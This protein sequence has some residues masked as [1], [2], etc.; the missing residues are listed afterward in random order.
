M[1]KLTLLLALLCATMMGWAFEENA[2]FP[3]AGTY[4]NQFYWTSIGGV[5][6]PMG[7][8]SVESKSG[9]DC[10]YVNVGQ[11]DFDPATGIVGC[12][13]AGYEGAGVWI[14]INSLVLADNEIYFKNSG[15]DI[16][17]G[18]VIHNN[19]AGAAPFDPASIDW[20]GVDF[21]TGQTQ[22]KIYFT[23]ENRPSNYTTI[24]IQTAPWA[25]N[26]TGIYVSFPDGVSACSLVDKTGCW[27]EGAQVLMYLTSF[28]DEVTEVTI[29]HA[30]G[31]K[32][33][34]VYNANAGGGSSTPV[35]PNSY[36]AGGHTISLDASYV[37]VD[38]TNKDYTLVITSADDME[39][40]GGSFWNVN[41]VGSDMRT[42]MVVSG[43]KKTITCT[44]T[45]T[46]NPNIYTPLYVLMP[47]E[48]NFGYVT[49]NWED[50]TPLTSEYCNYQGSETQQDGHYFAITWETDPS[51]NV[52]ITIGNGTGAGACSYRNG[53]FEGGNNGLNNF[54]VSDDDFASTTPATDYFTV[55]RPTDG[56][57]EYVLT[58]IADLPAGA[59]IK[60]LSAG[61]IAW[62]EAGADRWCY[63]EF[64][65]TYGAT[66]NQLDAPTNVAIDAN[67]IIT[68][69]AVAGADSY[70]AHVSLGGVEK[71]SQVV[72]S[73]DELTYTALVTGDYI[74]NVVA[75][76]AG[77]VDSDPS[78]DVVWHL[79]AA[80]I[81]LGN[82]E[83]CEANMSSGNTLA[84]FTWE[85]DGSGNIVITISEA[86]G[87]NAADTHFRGNALALANFKVGAGKAA[88]SNYFS[89]PGTTT[90]NQL[91]L[92]A[93]SAPALGEKIYYN[94]VVEYATSL[95]G[96]AWPTLDFEWTYGTECSGIAVS[97]TPN[98]STMGTAVVQ[99]AGVDVTNV[100]DGDEVTFIATVADAELY[101]FVNWTKAGIEVS[102]SATYVTTITET[103]N[104]VAN[105]DYVRN[106]YCHAEITSIQSKKL[107]MT[108]GSIGGG[109]YQI[110]FE[111]SAEAQLTGLNNANY[112][113]NW[114][115]TDIVDGDKK[116]SGQDV[117]FNNAR[118]AFDASGYGSATATFGIADGHTWEDIY[119]WNHAIYFSTAAGEV[120]YTGFPGRHNIDWTATCSDAEAP[121]IAKTEAQILNA[122]DVRLV[123]QATDNW[124]GQLTYTIT[125][126]GAADIILNGASGEE[127]TQDVTGLTT[128]TEYTF[129]VSV[130]DGVN[131]TPTSIVVTP[132]GDETK[133]VMGEASLASKTWNSAIINVAATDNVA[134]TA[135]YIVEL[136]A[137]YVPAEG[138]ITVTGLTAATAYTF[139]IK[140]KDAAGNIS[141][142]SAEV[143]FTTD[144]D[145]TEPTIAAPIPDK[146]AALVKSIYSDTYA[147]APA[148]L[149][150]YNEGW[151]K[152]PV[153][154]EKEISGN[155][156][157][158]YSGDMTGM[159]GWQFGEI[160]VASME[161]VHVDIWP[162][163]N[164]TINMGPTSPDSPNNQVASVALD[165]TGGQ[166]N[167]FDIPLSD[168]TTA[169]GAFNPTQLFQNQF[170][171]YSA[172][173]KFSVDNVYFYRETAIAD[174]ED[175]TA[176]T[177]SLAEESYFSVKINA[178]AED[179]SGAVVYTVK[180]GD[181][182]VA[183]QNAASAVA[184]TINVTGLNAGTAYN[185]NVYVADEA[186]NTL[187]PIELA[188]T[189]K[190]LPAA[191]PTPTHPA[192]AVRSIYSETYAS[193][194]PVGINYN[195]WWWQSPTI[196]QEV[197]LGGNNA[198]YY[199][200]LNTN[201]SFGITWNGDNK[202]D[203]AGYQK[204][205]F[206]IYPTNSATIEIYPVIQPEGEFHRTSATLVGGQWNEV[207]IDYTDKTFAPF[208]QFGIVY[209]NALGDFFID[210]LYFFRDPDYTRTEFLSAGVLGTICLPNNVPAGNAIGATFYA[211]DGK[212]GNG[213]M[214]FEEVSALEAGKPYIFEAQGD[215]IDVYY[216]TTNVEN[217]VN[218]GALQGTFTGVT[219]EVGEADNIYFFR[220]HALWS[221]KET[222]VQI[223]PNRAWLDMSVSIPNHAPKPGKRYITMGVNGQNATT[224]MDQISNDQSQM[225]NK[226][227]IDGHLYILRGEH[228]YNANGQ[229]VK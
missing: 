98:N 130:S 221:A 89:H 8:N 120:G 223:R 45:S 180:N 161:Y 97:A 177:A 175:P 46:S 148:S 147:F 186:G 14:K 95:E 74:I 23:E 210:N 100:N 13:L 117:P 113:I 50:R 81:V 116:M 38:G 139:T 196:A 90:G 15:G 4:A 118:W 109:Q 58:K 208:N 170:T 153:M 158:V 91:V 144:A 30:S 203:A 57:L 227:I 92:T 195:E 75:T 207:I 115:T 145:L 78:A 206:H 34:Y 126:A 200:G 154:T 125:R 29:T 44:A 121:V 24:N 224:G 184:T 216:G 192:V 59:K 156:Y 12:E 124:E 219:F 105:F 168:L 187:E 94:G 87:G 42:N 22:F 10:I 53:G 171:G 188:A 77:K 217:P 93:T 137:E 3:N 198:R 66:C 162:S 43:D 39:G 167:S 69:D 138:K 63:P 182:V 214:V 173:V 201:G 7:V 174:N 55:T 176:F 179:N 26:N 21:I 31:T 220:D 163:V 52:V 209:T 33:L 143:S 11:A 178:Q 108:L 41:G 18:L 112:T 82:S 169:N 128:G 132:V 157:L 229:L 134:V 85:T 194:I 119:V 27:I 111:G 36:T 56:D 80:P 79:E 76:G 215:Q 211:L 20:S 225:T 114:V 106:V 146:D 160:S 51:G 5:T 83:Y 155:H 218:S 190:T 164:G 54:V 9:F 142:D 19:A 183:T 222:G 88:G 104:L 28:V 37:S 35:D 127:L 159:V 165:V 122:T 6:A 226:V 135:Y 199:S 86:L 185:F 25:D 204:V 123:L 72:A 67:N 212:D 110:K 2:T 96:N 17:R 64:I 140:A 191:A 213:K 49:L 48:I 65:Y 151:W 133:P 70:I 129:N 1:R 166:W 150:S 149:N 131:T 47:G 99:K 107:Y 152:N 62:R 71:Y 61:A 101:R 189:T 103:A 205:H 136:D 193:A 84:A 181:A 16:L 172:Q 40:L 60:H 68:F 73:G 202:L 32:T 228:L 102:T 197:S 141:D